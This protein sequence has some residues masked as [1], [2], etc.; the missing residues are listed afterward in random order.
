MVNTNISPGYNKSKSDIVVK[1]TGSDGNILQSREGDAGEKNGNPGGA[2]V[3]SLVIPA[4]NEVNRIGLLLP[5]LTCGD[6]EYI[7]VC[8]GNDGTASEIHKWAVI[9][10]EIP[11][12]CIE[13]PSRIG[14]GKAVCDGLSLAKTSFAGYMDADGSAS[15]T[16]M[17]KLFHELDGSDGIIGSRWVTGAKIARSQGLFRK[18]ESRIFNLV[19]RVLFNLPYQ[20]TQC[21]AK[22][23]RKEALDM[24][25]PRIVSKGFE[26]D[27]ELI[28]RLRR[29][30]YVIREFPIEWDNRGDSRVKGPDAFSMI[31]NLIKLRLG[32]NPG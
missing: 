25:L 4:Y 2:A 13:Y 31:G 8:D 30:G 18:L 26:F 12:Q 17:L 11:L 6:V 20:D 14:K 32:W 9:H 7:F 3:F 5:D 21:G 10:P 1:A 29:E 15:C 24:V 19:I 27:V 23:F 16:Q 22:V 28:W